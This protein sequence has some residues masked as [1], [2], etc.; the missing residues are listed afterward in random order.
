MSNDKSNKEKGEDFMI[1]RKTDEEIER[2]QAE[3]RFGAMLVHGIPSP[4]CEYFVTHKKRGNV[5]V[6]S[7]ST[8]DIV[9]YLIQHAHEEGFKL[10]E[11]CQPEQM[12][13]DYETLQSILSLEEKYGHMIK[14]IVGSMDTKR[15]YND[16]QTV[17]LYQK[18]IEGKDVTVKDII[19]DYAQ[20]EKTQQQQKEQA[21]SQ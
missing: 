3:H 20:Y 13:H 12:I 17:A 10:L 19:N 6:W 8:E 11:Y 16:A 9:G 1:Y 18:R 21:I 7:L 4:V 2:L 15:L 5:D 14:D